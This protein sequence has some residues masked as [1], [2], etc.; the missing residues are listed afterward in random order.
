MSNL[1]LMHPGLLSISEFFMSL[2]TQAFS[3][4]TL[5]GEG[6][7]KLLSEARQGQRAVFEPGVLDEF[8]Y[9]YRPDSAFKRGEL[10]PLLFITLPHLSEDPDAL[11]FELE[12]VIRARPKAS[13]AEQL[14]F[15]FG[16]LRDRFDKQGWVERSGGSLIFL[17][18]LMKM[19]PEA[20]FIH[21]YRDG[22]DVA[23]SMQKHPPMRLFIRT[24][25][26]MNK[27][28]INPLKPPF[29]MGTS[30]IFTAME[31]IAYNFIDPDTHMEQPVSL[32]LAGRFWSDMIGIGLGNLS[33]LPPERV[34]S[35]RYEELVAQPEQE[36][37]RFM[38][39]LGPAFENDTWLRAAAAQP[40]KS[41][42]RWLSLQP[43][44]QEELTQACA[45]G[46]E[47]LGYPTTLE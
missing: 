28:G 35:L 4:R 17:P 41:T 32:D 1:I 31:G 24:W 46:L 27:I 38:A 47:K 37:R 26:R 3:H 23:L 15:L 13:Y 34:M 2:A 44:E 21:L 5:D 30:R 40:R 43:Q 36:L 7:W 42:P 11:Y 20:K 6:F 45:P 10:P 39:F 19:F 16:W 18:R 12:P 33:R 25:E 14:K 29:V 9:E 8:L 22:R